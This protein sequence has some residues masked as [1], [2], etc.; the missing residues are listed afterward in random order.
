MY[1]INLLVI[2]MIDDLYCLLT[3][4]YNHYIKL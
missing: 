4:Y 2:T 3:D 1:V